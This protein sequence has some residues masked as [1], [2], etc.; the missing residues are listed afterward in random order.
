MPAH[1][2]VDWLTQHRHGAP[3]MGGQ[4]CRGQQR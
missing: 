2:L 1:E 4:D 3:V